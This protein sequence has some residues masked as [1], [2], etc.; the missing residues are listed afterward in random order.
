MPIT[1]HEKL[2]ELFPADV[3]KQLETIAKEHNIVLTPQDDYIPKARFD[4]VNTEKNDF[5]TKYE[6]TNGEY[7]KLKPLAAGNQGLLDQ[8]AKMQTDNVKQKSDYEAMIAKRDKDYLI[9]DAFKGA[10]A[11]NLKA[12]RALIDY[13][14]INV[15]EGKLEGLDIE[16]LKKSDPYL[17]GEADQSKKFDAFGKEIVQNANNGGGGLSEAEQIAITMGVKPDSFQKK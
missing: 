6:S 8:I 10:K 11:K 5:K 14:K 7:E 16:A 2:K 1:I 9:D 13:D 3:V 15:K 4:A 12:A 17:F